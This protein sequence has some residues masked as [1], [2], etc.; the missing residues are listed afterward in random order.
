MD[1][2]SKIRQSLEEQYGEFNTN[3]EHEYENIVTENLIVGG[4]DTQRAWLTYNQ[5]ILELKHSLKDTL[6]VRELQYNLTDNTDPNQVC[7]ALIEGVKPR[8]PEL[9][10]LYLKISNFP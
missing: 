7:I 9:D 2:R 3:L 5:V 8:T 4:I 1:I 6:R 10:R